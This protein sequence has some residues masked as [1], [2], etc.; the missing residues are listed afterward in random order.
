MV[1]GGQPHLADPNGHLAEALRE[2][3]KGWAV[4]KPS[5]HAVLVTAARVRFGV[6]VKG[7]IWAAARDGSR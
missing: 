1:A 4:E 7:Y 3:R 6:N 2:G 5:N